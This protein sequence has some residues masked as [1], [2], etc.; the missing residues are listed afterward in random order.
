MKASM[1]AECALPSKKEDTYQSNQNLQNQD[2]K[3]IRRGPNAGHLPQKDIYVNK[4]CK[5]KSVI[6]HQE[7][8][9]LTS[10]ESRFCVGVLKGGAKE[11]RNPI[12]KKSKTDRTCRGTPVQKFVMQGSNDEEILAVGEKIFT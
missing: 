3:I 2:S 7:L 8:S 10:H 5:A 6:L 1:E 11:H 12:F 4:N 9:R